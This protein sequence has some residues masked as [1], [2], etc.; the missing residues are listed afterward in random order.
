[1]SPGGQLVGFLLV[2]EECCWDGGGILD[3]IVSG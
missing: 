1:M 2:Y 3:V